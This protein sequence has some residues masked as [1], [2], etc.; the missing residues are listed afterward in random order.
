MDARV[1]RS[2]CRIE[3][4]TSFYKHPVEQLINSILSSPVLYALLGLDPASASLA[5]LLAGAAELFYI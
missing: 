5:I 1:Q 2:A 3:V 4:L